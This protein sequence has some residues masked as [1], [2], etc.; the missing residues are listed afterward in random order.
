MFKSLQVFDA[1]N[2]GNAIESYSCLLSDRTNKIPRKGMLLVLP[3]PFLVKGNEI[4]FEAQACN[5]LARWAD[6][7]GSVIVVAPTIPEALAAEDKIT[8]WQNTTTLEKAERFELVPLPWA[9]KLSDF[10]SSYSQVR[11]Y[12]GELV[13][14]SEY[15]QFALGGLIGDWAAIAAL[16]AHKQGREYAIHTDW[17][18]HEVLL[19]SANR[20]NLK[21][22]FKAIVD[23]LLVKMYHKRIIQNCA[24]G[25]WHGQDCYSVYSSW[26]KN[27]YL[28]H[29][30]HLKSS[31]SI[32]KQELARKVAHTHCEAVDNTIRICY[33]GRIDPMKAPLE[34]VKSIAH[35]RDNGV[36]IQATWMGD[37][38]LMDEM[39]AL[40]GKLGLNS[41]IELTGFEQNRDKL[42]HKIR[43]SHI[44]L[45]T[46]VT[47]ESPRCLIEALM[48][49][50]PIIG[51]QSDYP[52]EL[53]GDFG[54]GKFVP[55]GD[56]KKLGDLLVTL[57]KDRQ[58]LSQLIQEAGENGQRFNDEAV[59][60]HRSNSIKKHLSGS[61]YQEVLSVVCH[62]SANPA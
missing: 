19:K 15:L 48:C 17:V 34:W 50:T 24:V 56:W 30:I 32:G 28:I 29:N 18:N 53:V 27:S 36:N 42:L 41:Y 9:Y 31:D 26:C 6:N 54:G 13:S 43:E 16:E 22:R 8:I 21:K 4:F 10:L 11:A 14:R 39:K 7:F 46:H 33:A 60:L 47:P 45:F 49:G 38:I 3:V 25:L 2:P 37:G 12:L 59:F 40:I 62:K 55:M 23:A 20:G 1:L 57:S 51:Y 35:A 52:V 61:E 44:M 58:R 5:G